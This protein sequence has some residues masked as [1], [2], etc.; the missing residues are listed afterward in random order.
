MLERVTAGEEPGRPAPTRLISSRQILISI[1]GRWISD[2]QARQVDAIPGQICDRTAFV[3]ASNARRV[4]GA[5]EPWPAPET[6]KLM[7]AALSSQARALAWQPLILRKEVPKGHT[8]ISPL[9]VTGSR[10]YC[11]PARLSAW[12]HSATSVRRARMSALGAVPDIRL[13]TRKSPL[14]AAADLS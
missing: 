1:K 7:I 14:K 11:Q 3:R 10:N 12:G 13:C 4:L 2:V 5:H 8:R 6:A 9:H